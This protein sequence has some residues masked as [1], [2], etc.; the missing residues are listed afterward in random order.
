ME[1]NPVKLSI[2]IPYY[3]TW[4][5]THELLEAL[6]KQMTADVEVILI[7][8]GSKDLFKAEYKWLHIMRQKNAGT[9]AA[10]NKG[11]DIAKGEYITFIDSDDMVSEHY[12]ER[13]FVAMRDKPD[14][15]D[16]SWRSMNTNQFFYKT[17]EW[18]PLENPSAC[19]RVFKRSFVGDK[20]F[21][22]KKD[23]G[24]D[25]DFTRHLG[26]KKAKRGWVDKYVYF[27]RT[28]VENS[29]SKR[30]MQGKTTT[31]QIVYYYSQV[32]A[33]M[34]WLF[35]EIK[36]EDEVNEVYLMTKKCNLP[37]IEEYCRVIEPQDIWAHDKRGE[38]NNY[39][40][41]KLPAERSQVIIYIDF[42]N[43]ADGLTTWIHN[44]CATM[45]DYYDITV[46]HDELP[47][48]Q[49]NR[50]RQHVFVVKNSSKKTFDCD[51]LLMMRLSNRIPDNITYERVYQV[52]HC[53]KQK[54]F[55]LERNN[56]IFV[57][58][59]AKNSFGVEGKVI[60]NLPNPVTPPRSLMLMSTTRINAEDK[61]KQDVRMLT[62]AKR[63]NDLRIP[64]IWLYF[65]EVKLSGAPSNMIRIDPVD[66]VREFLLHADYLVHLSD[67][68]AYCYS[69]QEALAEGIGVITTDMPVLKELGFRDGIDGHIVP[70][71]MNYDFWKILEPLNPY[72]IEANVDAKASIRQWKELLGRSIPQRSYKAPRVIRVEVLTEY[73]DMELGKVL[74]RGQKLDMCEDRA[75]QL[76]ALGLVKI[77]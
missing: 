53:V 25:E 14:Y 6:D 52:V 29:R 64:F 65:S 67:D 15:I 2:I 50:L 60:Y 4:K 8:D 63:L 58:K 62:M 46:V 10:R 39:V 36:K 38:P 30:Y 66:D 35:E 56:C 41:V 27:Y 11:I 3:N 76:K 71:N 73:M 19:T 33:D 18:E 74:D 57:S 17:T 5:Y 55:N 40:H 54:K 51:T 9:S 69:I 49:I 28:E 70:K 72:E 26:L 13:V 12:I 47:I 16:L 31:R 48:N 61:G 68:E 59:T 44:F 45:A 77:L 20:R 75:E 7:D 43:K 22:V 24:E 23:A 34:T 1:R 37:G 32:T 42:T 21:N